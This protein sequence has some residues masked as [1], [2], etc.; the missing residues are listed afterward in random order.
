MTRSR[1]FIA[2]GLLFVRL[3]VGAQ[4]HSTDA[5]PSEPA[6]SPE[7]KQSGWRRHF[8]I[9]SK[10]AVRLYEGSEITRLSDS[11]DEK[12][13]LVRDE[14]HGDFIIRNVWNF[15]TQTV[16]HRISDLQ[17]RAF[18][19]LSYKMPFTSRTRLETLAEA[20][21]TPGLL[22]PASTLLKLETNGGT[23]EGFEA[24]WQ[25]N[26]A[27]LR[28]LRHGIRSTLNGFILEA[29]ERGR[30]LLFSTMEGS[31]FFTILGRYAVYGT[32][33]TDD[34]EADPDLSPSRTATPNCEFDNAFGFPCSEKQKS[35]LKKAADEGTVVEMY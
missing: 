28:E 22:S 5:K 29:I 20:R 6:P 15:K 31:A 25:G 24:D 35:F 8:V 14:G 3:A 19:Q 18:F 26:P 1:Y 11:A 33:L 21:L 7:V 17:D 23:W 4:E 13:L 30:G 9:T 10:D 32:N 34:A 27:Q 16:Q 12:F 2:V